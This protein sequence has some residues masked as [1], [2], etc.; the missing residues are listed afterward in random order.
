MKL[1]L[2][3]VAQLGGGAAA[4][5]SPALVLCP[6]GTLPD[7]RG[8][9]S[10]GRTLPDGRGPVSRVGRGSVSRNW[11]EAGGPR[12]IRAGGGK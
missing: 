6:P 11:D 3:E 5:R 7:G 2:G 12:A 9:A 10:G 4:G 8:S 1:T